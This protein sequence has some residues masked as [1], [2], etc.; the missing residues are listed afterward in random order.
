LPIVGKAAGNAR[1]I[2]GDCQD[3]DDNK[4]QLHTRLGLAPLM[5]RGEPPTSSTP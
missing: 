2:G 1:E 3:R 4:G 5:S